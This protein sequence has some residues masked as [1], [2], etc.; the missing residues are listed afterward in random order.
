MNRT[1]GLVGMLLLAS[2]AWGQPPSPL[3]FAPPPPPPPPPSPVADFPPLGCEDLS[4]P[5]LF[6]GVEIAVVKPALSFGL[7]NQVGIGTPPQFLKVPDVAL[8]TTIS[9][10]F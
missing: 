9:P 8:G 5:G 1:I 3:A 6:A 4:P 2:A 7:M 10:T